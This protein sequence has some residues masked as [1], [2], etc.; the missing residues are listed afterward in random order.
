MPLGFQAF[1]HSST[2]FTAGVSRLTRRVQRLQ[3]SSLLASAQ[4]AAPLAAGLSLLSA[5]PWPSQASTSSAAAWH[6]SR[7]HS[8][9]PTVETVRQT[10][11]SIGVPD[12]VPAEPGT[13]TSRAFGPSLRLLS[14]AAAIPHPDKAQTGGEDAHFISEDGLALGVADGVGGWAEIGVDAGIYARLLMDHANRAAGNTPPGPNAPGAILKEAHAK[15]LVQGSSTACVLVLEGSRLHAANLG[16]SGF[17]VL[18]GEEVIFRSPTQQHAFN[19]PYQL[20]SPGTN[21]DPPAVAELFSVDVAAGD[22]VICGT[23]GLWDNVFTEES[24]T[25]VRTLHQRGD[26]PH[27][28]AAALAQFARIRGEDKQHMS[29]FAA[30]AQ[31]C[32][33]A[34]NGGKLDDITVIVSYI[35]HA[36]KL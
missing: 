28:A 35:S 9:A 14:G 1:A 5:A 6:A 34:Y 24:V 32:G 18:R 22:V 16:D 4:R 36:P 2:A 26:N 20:G 11:D 12:T 7:L 31:A 21:S 17:F 23:D 8:T 30:G 3:F 13:D 19:F 29:P 10:V 33:H 25:I 15:A 27:V